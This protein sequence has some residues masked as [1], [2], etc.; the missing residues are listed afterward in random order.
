[1]KIPR[2]LWHFG[3]MGLL[4]PASANAM[5]SVGTL[6]PSSFPVLTTQNAT[7]TTAPAKE[8]PEAPL[9]RRPNL[10]P[11]SNPR[12]PSVAPIN[13]E[14]TESP[15]PTT[16][17]K[18]TPAPV[19]VAS[20]EP[21]VVLSFEPSKILTL[22]P[23][24]MERSSVPTK[25]ASVSPVPTAAPSDYRYPL[26]TLSQGNNVMNISPNN[27]LN[28]ASE[29][30]WEE[31]TAKQIDDEIIKEIGLGNVD[32]LQVI[33]TLS[34]QEPRFITTKPSMAPSFEPPTMSP[35]TVL[36]SRNVFLNGRRGR[37][38]ADVNIQ[39]DLSDDG[40]RLQT[41]NLNILFSVTINIR[42]SAKNHVINEY[43]SGA[44]DTALDRQRYLAQLKKADPAFIN[45]QR[46]NVVLPNKPP[47]VAPIA[48][49]EG[50][51]L[52]VLIGI[53]VAILA[54]VAIAGFAM[55][56][57]R[58]QKA[59][60]F[61][62]GTTSLANEPGMELEGAVATGHAFSEIELEDK[63]NDVS[64][65]GDP[66]P[67]H[68]RNSEQQS[69]ADSFSLDYDYQRTYR[70]GGGPSVADGSQGDSNHSGLIVA[71]DDDTLE[72][73]Y[74][75]ADQFEV[76]APAGMLG[77]VLEASGDGVPTV[78]AIKPSSPLASDIQVGDRLWSLDGEDMT[79]MLASDVSRLIA[80]KRDNLVRRFVFSRPPGK[81]QAVQS[82]TIVDDEY[83]D[84][85][86]R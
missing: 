49:D 7:A 42:S 32:A 76:E 66:I 74:A 64:T 65:L 57:L 48:K 41:S 3:V 69:L 63:T 31:I 80:R 59:A 6:F 1:M 13:K 23:T 30:I 26:E 17:K 47:T 25:K 70:Q 61:S 44:F 78:H 68:F 51:A 60:R 22:A 71:K 19:A 35:S 85:Y 55:L 29:R 9:S 21:T 38:D 82:G 56:R 39:D 36:P 4:L 40:R 14:P 67:A 12:Q 37:V 45:A 54:L 62:S 50:L 43:I 10:S 72:E 33:I 15:S 24:T 53:V 58:R 28:P 86:Q 77:L 83:N 52:E 20:P 2:R 84:E 27:P 75:A 34:S 73:Q 18:P 81:G 16:Q 11:T 79:V 8:T 5:D 46:L